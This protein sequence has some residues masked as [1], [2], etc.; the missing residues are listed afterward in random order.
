[1]FAEYR[2]YLGLQ[3]AHPAAALWSFY[4]VLDAPGLRDAGEALAHDALREI[5]DLPRLP[6]RG[7]GVR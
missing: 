2:D 6:V 7:A 1:M 5:A 4:H 3:R